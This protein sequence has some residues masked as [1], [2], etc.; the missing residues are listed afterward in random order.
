MKTL[1]FLLFIFVMAM[2]VTVNAIGQTNQDATPKIAHNA[3]GGMYIQAGNQLGYVTKD[4]II[5]ASQRQNVYFVDK[6]GNVFAADGKKVGFAKKNGFYYN[7]NGNN[8][9]NTTDAEKEQ[10]AALDPQGHNSG[11]THNNVKQHD[12]ATHCYRLEQEKLNKGKGAKAK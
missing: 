7:L 10:C 5:K 9:L 12:C 3:K 8:V 6:N 2:F 1:N 4:N 11:T